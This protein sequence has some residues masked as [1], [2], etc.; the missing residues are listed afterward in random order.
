LNIG[1]TQGR[2]EGGRGRWEGGKGTWGMEREFSSTRGMEREFRE[3][4][5]TLAC[6]DLKMV[7]SMLQRKVIATA[8]ESTACADCTRLST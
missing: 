6:M 7:S 1:G 3:K 8:P 2:E 5:G 4:D